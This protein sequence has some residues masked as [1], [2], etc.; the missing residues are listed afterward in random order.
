M[1]IE[2]AGLTI[3]RKTDYYINQNINYNMGSMQE[4]SS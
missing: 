4:R 2:I 3:T 1:N